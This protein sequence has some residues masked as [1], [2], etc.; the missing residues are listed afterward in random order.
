MVSICWAI[1]SIGLIKRFVRREERMMDTR[2][3]RKPIRITIGRAFSKWSTCC[4]FA[5]TPAGYCH[6]AGAAHN[7]RYRIPTC[8]IAA[9]PR[10][11]RFAGPTGFRAGE[12]IFH[13]GFVGATFILNLPAGSNQG[14]THFIAG[15]YTSRLGSV[16]KS[17]FLAMIPALFCKS[18]LT[19]S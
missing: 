7:N 4:E 10:Q 14:N 8:W 17:S 15:I 6:F 3:I 1:T 13:L 16:R 11:N 12:M 2:R 9:L 19:C 5:W 18:S